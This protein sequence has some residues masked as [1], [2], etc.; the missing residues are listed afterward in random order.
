MLAVAV[1]LQ[2]TASV[3]IYWLYCV[4]ITVFVVLGAI[5]VA[6]K[7][8]VGYDQEGEVKDNK[9]L[10]AERTDMNFK[11]QSTTSRGKERRYNIEK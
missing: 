8:H 3:M 11:K 6:W 5:T 10:D 9:E 1:V 7:H 4:Y 2:F